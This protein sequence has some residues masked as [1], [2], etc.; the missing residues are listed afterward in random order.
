[1]SNEGVLL[2]VDPLPVDPWL[3]EGYS[4]PDPYTLPNI[5]DGKNNNDENSWL[6]KCSIDE[7]ELTLN[8][9]D[10]A[11]KSILLLTEYTDS[12]YEYAPDRLLAYSKYSGLLIIHDW[13]VLHVLLDVE[14][15]NQ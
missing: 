11:T 2:A 13:K 3:E 5:F 15:G 1:M 10:Y 14:P 9:Q 7:D 6:I 4:D 8:C 12:V